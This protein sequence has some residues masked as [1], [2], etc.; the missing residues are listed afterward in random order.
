M[1][2]NKFIPWVI[3]GI[4]IVLF[5]FRENYNQRQLEEANA[6]IS[7]FQLQQQVL[8]DSIQNKCD[9][10]VHHIKISFF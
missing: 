6:E 5:I 7:T 8:Q 2:T 1:K 10:K 3:L 4:T 9:K